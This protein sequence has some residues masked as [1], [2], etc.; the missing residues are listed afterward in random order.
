MAPRYGSRNPTKKGSVKCKCSCENKLWTG[1]NGGRYYGA[2]DSSG[3]YVRRYCGKRLGDKSGRCGELACPQMKSIRPQSLTMREKTKYAKALAS[4]TMGKKPSAACLGHFP[5]RLHR[6]PREGYF[7]LKQGKKIYVSKAKVGKIGP[8]C[9]RKVVRP[10][11]ASLTRSRK[12]N[13][14]YGPILDSIRSV[15]S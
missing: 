3:T 13:G 12:S 14:S 11:S 15:L 4:G 10:Q 1:K 2:Y 6:G 8:L 5:N 9:A 7:Y